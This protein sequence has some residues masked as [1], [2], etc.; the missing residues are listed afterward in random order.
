MS[1]GDKLAVATY[2]I[3]GLGQ[4]VVDEKWTNDERSLRDD[5]EA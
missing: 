2:V 1:A 5:E 4:D 3:A